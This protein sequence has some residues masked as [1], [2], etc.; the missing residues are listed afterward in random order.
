M[1]YR[2]SVLLLIVS[3]FFSTHLWA[4]TEAD[5][6][7]KAGAGQKTFQVINPDYKTSPHTGMT[8]Q[9]WKDAAQYLLEGAF[10]YVKTVEDPMVF[11]KQPG[12]S[13]PRDG[14]HTPTE[15][16]EG[17]CRTLFVAVP[18]LKEN[19]NLEING[20]K[21]ADYY[22]RQLVKLTEPTSPTYVKPR[23][24]NGGPSQ[25]LVEFGGLAVSLFYAP[26][27]LW[28]PLTPP[29]KEILSK[30]MLS[31][32][33]GPTIGSNWRFFNI[34]VMS[35]F[36]EQGYPVNEKLMLEYLDKSLEQYRGQG[37]YNDSPAYDYYSMW[38]FQMY[39]PLWAEFFGK[40]HHP[41]YAARFV[42]NFKEL[43]ENYPYL[44][45]RDG[46]MIMWGRS[47]AYRF[48]AVVPFPLMGLTQEPGTNYGWMRR[49]A[50]GTILQFLQNPDFMAP[51]NIPTLGFYGA[52][53]PA[54]QIYSAR[55]S[56]FWMGKAFLGLIVPEGNPFWTAVENEGAWEKELSKGNVYNKFQEGSKILITDYPNIGAAEVRAW[57]HETVAKD[58]Q[59]FRST[60]NYNRLSYN[61]A[62]PWQADGPNGEVAMNYVI[63][64]QKNEWEALRLFTFKKF[65]NGIYYRDAV[66]E[67]N[68]QIKLSLADVPLPNGILRV[69]L[70]T[71][72]QASQLRLGHYALP[73]LKTAI[74]KESRKVKGHPVQI[75]DNGEY[76]LALV[77]LSGWDGLEAVNATGLHPVSKESTVLTVTDQF[78][79]SQKSEV[80]ATLMLWKKSGE[81]WTDE[82][83][84]PVKK[85]S[86]AANGKS[87]TVSFRKGEAKTVRF[88]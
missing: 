86:P 78:Q 39:G 68:D 16:L 9:H 44:F 80:Y 71:S 56:A 83:L 33:D 40:K 63:K 69:D 17:L 3:L 61:S 29:Q 51:D 73:Q 48:A 76:Q 62:F 7:V 28:K 67:T 10:Q 15:M 50:S 8:R 55:A 84:V 19:P 57:C 45:S 31:Y 74:R 41:E 26:D 30:T 49:I 32:G 25:I 2:A 88:E 60:E 75:I 35:F 1:R 64:N 65:D 20:I 12:K 43:D 42:A 6:T 81:K 5:P 18:L 21:V 34:F 36:K 79:P 72:T 22:R 66:L 46:Q 53:E 59:L 54:V 47:I 38:A 13:Y 87:F 11:P 23:A 14:V 77:S 85:I 70:N 24:S 37:W 4:Q 58:W 82:E 52:Y 27:V